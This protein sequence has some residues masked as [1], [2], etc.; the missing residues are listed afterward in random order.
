VSERQ[1]TGARGD[2]AKVTIFVAVPPPVA[3]DLFTREIDLWW[4]RGPK[5]RHSGRHAGTLSF[6]GGAGGRL[7]ETFT[8]GSEP[9]AIEVGRILA[10]QPP[11]LLQLQWRSSNF[12]PHEKTEVVVRFVAAG[13][14][15][16]VSVEHRGW[17]ALRPDH[18]ARHGLDG[19]AFSGSLGMW[20]TELLAALRDHAQPK[21]E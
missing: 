8:V 1:R 6:E 13:D 3:F 10:W 19:A 18:P 4:K 17:S 7:F 20:W 11:E 14:G 2:R 5:F 21:R 9:R 12:A 16:E 15:T